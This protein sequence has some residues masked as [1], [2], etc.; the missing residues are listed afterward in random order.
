MVNFTTINMNE[1]GYDCGM[2]GA[3]GKHRHA[4]SVDDCGK[5]TTRETGIGRVVCKPCHD[6]IYPPT[7]EAPSD[8]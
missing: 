5:P 1:R 6:T 4:V 2:C 8:E 7:K 3:Y